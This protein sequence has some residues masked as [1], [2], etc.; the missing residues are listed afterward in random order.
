MQERKIPQRSKNIDIVV[1]L[2]PILFMAVYYYGLRVLV[3]SAYAI[4]FSLISDY[5]CIRLKGEKKWQKYDFSPII[6][7]LI[8]VLVLPAST[9]FWLV[10]IGV[11]VANV[12]AKHPFGGVGANIFNPAAVAVAF[13]TICWPSQVLMYP[14][15]FDALGLQ[16]EVTTQLFR[17][18][19]Y[20]LQLGGTPH[21][22]F[23]DA[24][25]GN[26][27]GP[28]GATNILVIVMCGVYLLIRRS[29]SW[30][31]VL[32]TLS[33]TTLFAFL[34]PRIIAGGKASVVYETISGMLVFGVIFMASDPMTSPKT[35]FGKALYG[36]FLGLLT[37]MFRYLGKIEIGF[38]YALLI[39]N[40]LSSMCDVYAKNIVDGL[41]EFKNGKFN[42]S[43]KKEAA[44]ND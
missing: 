2:L 12:V 34:I 1:T 33:T 31:I 24:L 42:P 4:I 9:P 25:L 37:M 23:M 19:A 11:L 41:R 29:V 20:N 13:V 32:A 5:L 27:A 40:A 7:A 3:L 17:G 35:G 30:Q 10:I 21:I 8:F 43:N 39:M 38:V 18:V 14:Q 36:I 16:S 6:T 44:L 28:M 15:P 22:S 26:F